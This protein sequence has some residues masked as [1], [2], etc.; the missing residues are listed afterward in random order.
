MR[1][2]CCAAGRAV[3]NELTQPLNG[4]FLVPTAALIASALLL[5]LIAAI[6]AWRFRRSWRAQGH[7]HG[8]PIVF[9]P[10]ASDTVVPPPVRRRPPMQ[11]GAALEGAPTA[12]PTRSNG[13]GASAA[14]TGGTPAYAHHSGSAAAAVAR[15]VGAM[16]APSLV[17][18]RTLRF[19][20]APAGTLQMLPGRLEVVEGDDAGRE[21]R[22]VR[23]GTGVQRVTFGRREGAPY[24]HVQLRAHTVSREHAALAYVDGAWSVENLS[25]TNPVIV[26]GRELAHGAQPFLLAEGDLIEMGEVVF[27]YRE[28]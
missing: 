5:V 20:A 9:F 7:A 22:F 8:P 28:R 27:R 10:P 2:L 16:P 19:H 14:A 17:E 26:N 12:W 13:D 11:Q 25:Q 24:E 18:A 6:I 23:L 15:E 3:S 21:L 1:T 4:E